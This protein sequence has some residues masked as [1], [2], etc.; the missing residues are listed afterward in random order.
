MPVSGPF[1]DAVVKRVLEG[2]L[3]GSTLEPEELDTLTGLAGKVGIAYQR[4]VHEWYGGASMEWVVR[5]FV[6]GRQDLAV[7]AIFVNDVDNDDEHV[8]GDVRVYCIPTVQGGPFMRYTASRVNQRT[9]LPL[10]LDEERFIDELVEEWQSL[11]ER[12]G[13]SDGTDDSVKCP[14]CGV[15][16]ETRADDEEEEEG[17]EKAE[18]PGPVFCGGCGQRLPAPGVTVEQ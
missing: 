3:E 11:A 17:A 4:F 14:H 13:V 10:V 18:D 2:V 7:F 15:L 12:F 8:P 5:E 6:Q 16:T 1:I 9:L